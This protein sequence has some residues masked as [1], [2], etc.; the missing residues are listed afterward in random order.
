MPGLA[1]KADASTERGPSLLGVCWFSVGALRPERVCRSASFP[2]ICLGFASKDFAGASLSRF[3][4][5]A[6]LAL[7][8]GAVCPDGF[9]NWQPAQNW[10][11][12]VESDCL[13]KTKRCDGPA[14]V[15]TQRDFCPVL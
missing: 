10:H 13:I 6:L 9:S 15:L 7:V 4:S 3:W 5:P 11:G 14:W 2:K 12:L 1:I 8:R